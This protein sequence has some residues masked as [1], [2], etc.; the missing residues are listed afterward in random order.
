MIPYFSNYV[1]SKDGILLKKSSGVKIE[2]SKGVGGYYTYRMTDDSGRTQNR[3]RH[4]ILGYAFKPY[5]VNVDELDINHDNGKPGNDWLDNLE[6]ST[7]SENN[8]HAVN[9]GLRNDNLDVEV[10]NVQTGRRHLFG[11]CTQAADILGVTPATVCNRARSN[12]Y[13]LYGGMQYRFYPSTEEWPTVEPVGDFVAEF[14][15]GARKRCDGVEAARLAG[16]SRTS[17]LRL[18]RE[19]RNTGKS[20]VKIFRC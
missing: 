20:N 13:K 14:Q 18:L 5:P 8:L 15:D 11:S 16:V 4:R 3:Y 17:L 9:T 7:R 2:A 12:G 1:I 6:W 19:G 10:R